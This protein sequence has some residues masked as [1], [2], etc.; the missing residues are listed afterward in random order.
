MR[1]TYHPA[2]NA[3]R[4]REERERGGGGRERGV[5]A[6]ERVKGKGRKGWG[7][8]GMGALSFGFCDLY[9]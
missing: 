3:H 9:M 2:V 6:G 7:V 5:E 1:L 8:G 4:F